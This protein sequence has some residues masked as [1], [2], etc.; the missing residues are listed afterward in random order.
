MSELL[1]DDS[2]MQEELVCTKNVDEN[3]TPCV[4]KGL[5]LS[6]HEAKAQRGEQHQ[7]TDDR[8]QWTTHQ[9][10]R[11]LQTNSTKMRSNTLNSTSFSTVS[12]Y[13]RTGK[14]LLPNTTPPST[15]TKEPWETCSGS[16]WISPYLRRRTRQGRRLPWGH[17]DESNPLVKADDRGDDKSL[18]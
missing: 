18:P 7:T 14:Y 16:R 2:R 3:G 5:D 9:S 8:M 4:F 6:I 12:A 13:K 10:R 17:P 1:F 11:Q 15:F